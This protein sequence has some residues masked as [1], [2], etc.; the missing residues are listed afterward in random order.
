MTSAIK[1]KKILAVAVLRAYPVEKKVKGI[2]VESGYVKISVCI[3]AFILRDQFWGTLP[4]GQQK[5]KP[6]TEGQ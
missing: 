5:Y 3:N 4:A 2:A 6:E 1:I